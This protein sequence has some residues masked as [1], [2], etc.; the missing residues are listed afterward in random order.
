MNVNVPYKEEEQTVL[1][2]KG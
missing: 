2:S 1:T